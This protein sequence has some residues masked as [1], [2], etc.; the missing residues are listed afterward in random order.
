MKTIIINAGPRKRGNTAQLLHSAMEGAQAAGGEV[1]YIDL[2]DLQFTGC[3][4]CMACKRKGAEKGK[5]YWKDDL[6][7]LI[8]KI[9]QADN[10]IIGSPM[11]NATTTSAMHALLERMMFSNLSYN[12]FSVAFKG[13]LNVGVIITMNADKTFYEAHPS[14]GLQQNIDWFNYFGGKVETL[15]SYNSLNVNDY[16]KFDMAAIDGEAK[17]EYHATVFEE[18]KKLAHELGYRIGN[19]Q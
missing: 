9:F 2:Y 18:D 3:R 4:S 6:S 8:D 19:K 16:S 14:L 17:K 10:L 15:Y 12:D 11:Y 7:P 5:C 1:E 13:K